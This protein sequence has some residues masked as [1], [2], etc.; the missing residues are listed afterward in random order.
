ML[1]IIHVIVYYVKG[2]DNGRL[3]YYIR[4]MVDF[5]K[6]VLIGILAWTFII[7]FGQILTKLFL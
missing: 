6:T 2:V 7:T 1:I 5:L 3:R 4:S